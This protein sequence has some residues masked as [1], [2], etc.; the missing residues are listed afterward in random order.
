[1]ILTM[2]R[3]GV[4]TNSIRSLANTRWHGII[5]NQTRFDS[6]PALNLSRSIPHAKPHPFADARNTRA[7]GRSNQQTAASGSAV[8]A[9]DGE[10]LI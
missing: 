6:R 1:M 10:T 8:F 2:R 3:M 7:S 5:L 4:A 9:S